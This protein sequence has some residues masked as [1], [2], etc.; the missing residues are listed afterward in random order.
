MEI[1]KIK[2]DDLKPYEKNAKLHPKEQIE[3]IKKSIEQFGMND[4]IG[5]WGKD[6]LIVEGHGRL[7]ALKQ[8]GYDEVECIRLDHLSDE[9][10]RAYTLAHN[11][12]TMNSDFDF[13]ILND[14]LESIIDIDMENFGFDMDFE[15]EKEIVEDE[16]PDKPLKTNIKKGDIFQLGKHRL[17][18]GDSTNEDNINQ[19][20]NNNT[21]KCVFTSPPYNMNANM[22][23]GYN[24]NLASEEYIKFNLKVINN[25]KK[26]LKGF[27]FW[28]ISYNKNS[29]W[30]FIEIMYRIIKD[31]GLK[32]MEL[33][34]WDKGHGMP[35]TSKDMLTRR[36]EDILMVGD[37]ESIS[38]DMDLYCIG[39]T[40]KQAY[41]NK[42]TDK[43]IT[44]YWKVDTNNSQIKQNKACFPV[45]LPAKA[46]KLCTLE[47][48]NIMEP[49]GGSGS[50]LIA[51]E[52]LN[53]NCFIM[54]YDEILCQLIID[55]W[56][57]F[58]GKKAV[59][60]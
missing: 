27:L 19:L 37:E 51:C 23:D 47:N 60:L 1:V 16:I 2:I 40:E 8:L 39:T 53:R 28:N 31:T 30:E 55:R 5:I 18:C 20:I 6:N 41:F 15:K 12:L 50:T 45:N 38:Q 13:D 59:K 57:N 52:Q 33:I 44:N 49:F 54:E 10:R 32:F 26:N 21:I 7:E 11:K 35:I 3:Q 43:G 25:I 56:E 48:E 14:E 24:D 9:E 34:V 36:Y 29:R 58:T 46:I 22:Y 17:M 4:P 42:K